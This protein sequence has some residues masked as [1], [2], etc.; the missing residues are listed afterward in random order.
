M[1]K[2]AVFILLG[3]TIGVAF[4]AAFAQDPKNSDDVAEETSEPG[5]PLA[6]KK[7]YKEISSTFAGTLPQTHIS[8]T[9]LDDA[10]AK[11]A[12]DNFIKS[13]DY[14]RTLFLAGEIEKFRERAPNLD[15][16][17]KDGELEFAYDVFEVYRE[18]LRNRVGFAKIL[19]EK[20]FDTSVEEEYTWK[21][22]EAPW[23][24]TLE[25]RDD[26]WRRKIKHEFVSR[27]VGKEM[28]KIED[29]EED[30]EDEKK[31]DED[32]AKDKG[33]AED[34]EKTTADINKEQA[35]ALAKEKRERDLNLSPEKWITKKYN[36]YLEVVEGHD[37]EYVLQIYL[38]SFAHSYD[39]HTSY[40]S[41][42][43]LEDFEITM[44]LSLHGIGA[45][46][47][48]EEGTAEIIKVI[49]GGPAER[50]GRLHPGDR[51]VAVEQEGEDPVD[52]MY[53]PLYKSVRLI[54]GEK[55]TTVIL[56]VIPKSD[57]NGDVIQIDLV[58]DK[59]KLE[60][61]AAKSRIKEFKGEGDVV[62][63]KLGVIELPDFYAD[64]GARRNGVNEPRSCATDVKK[65]LIEMNKEKVDGL[66]FDLRNNGGGSLPDCVE[67]TGYFI[68]SGPIVQVQ[69]S[70]RRPYPLPDPSQD[71]LFD[72][73]MVVL[74]NRQ[75]ASASE[76][77]AAALQDYGRAIIVG[78]SKTH[79]K[80]SVQTLY[81]LERGNDALG[82]LKV[83]TAGFYRIDGRSTQL[84]G[85]TPDIVIPSTLDA[86]EIGEEYLD[87]V[88]PWN[89]IAAARYSPSGDLDSM[90]TDLNERSEERREK[91]PQFAAQQDLIERM[92]EKLQKTEISLNL[93]ERI[94]LAKA[95]K[96][97]EDMRKKFSN[98]DDHDDDQ[99]AK[100]ANDLILGEGL[101]ILRDMI[102][103]RSQ[104]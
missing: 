6:P 83:T 42:R 67:L 23:P 24:E 90:I 72:G 13:M 81:P 89:M 34:K 77:L 56:H 9:M 100:D 3:G 94:S 63:Y 66:V 47:S 55:G 84:K 52:I 19:L 87:N 37:T 57:A 58:R 15:D 33:D 102:A 27:L 82:S 51:I 8:H 104:I 103:V 25:E 93:E 88:L 20:G 41:Q 4:Y 18:H 80:G 73:P 60:D 16:D 38:D 11:N 78:D 36:Q 68:E 79:G 48:A 17:I 91:S 30:D 43:T 5:G 46:L 26:L 71:I 32:L 31:D 62:P 28:R 69:Q 50:D 49:G 98:D 96:E 97:L 21:R 7:I 54:R 29:A 99:D 59:I 10:K 92:E 85:V 2:F 75:S 35:E 14:D 12:F 101:H 39:T 61:R 74:V 40:M 86:L 76:I 65:L 70:G 95:D 64:M 22:K 44:K 53:W 1:K 45:L